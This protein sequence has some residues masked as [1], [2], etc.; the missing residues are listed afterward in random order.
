MTRFRLSTVSVVTLN[1]GLQKLATR[2]SRDPLS[3][4]ST[5]LFHSKNRQG[6]LMHL[7]R[8]HYARHE[9]GAVRK[10]SSGDQNGG[11]G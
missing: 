8:M 7:I 4:S 9:Y 2:G 1:R 6:L 10:V 11:R 3:L 5:D